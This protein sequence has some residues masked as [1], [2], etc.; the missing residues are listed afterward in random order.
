MLRKHKHERQDWIVGFAL[1]ELHVDLVAANVVVNV[2]EEGSVVE[3]IVPA[4][5]RQSF[6][7]ILAV[8]LQSLYVLDDDVFELLR[9]EAVL[10]VKPTLV[11]ALDASHYFVVL[12]FE[13]LE[14]A[15][16]H[17]RLLAI[18]V[19]L[20]EDSAVVVIV[21]GLPGL[22]LGL[23]LTDHVCLKPPCQF[24]QFGD[25]APV[26]AALIVDVVLVFEQVFAVLFEEGVEVTVF[27]D[28]AKL[29]GEEVV[30][31]EGH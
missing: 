18:L 14:L 22:P 3:R 13:L 5:R 4:P 12:H 9:V 27:E 31:D 15:V 21:V 23:H 24:E 7:V 1:L 29:V 11:V 28:E 20:I 6:V 17:L 8:E 19:L 26:D 16:L 2:T 10:N 30:A 25:V